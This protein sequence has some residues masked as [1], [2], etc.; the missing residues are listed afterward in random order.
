MNLD[1]FKILNR[2][3]LR[4]QVTANMM[5]TMKMEMKITLTTMKSVT[6]DLF[7]MIVFM[8]PM[9]K[10]NTV[11]ITMNQVTVIQKMMTTMMTIMKIIVNLLCMTVTKKMKKI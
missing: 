4:T 5:T 1:Y 7:Q 10:V 8:I 2:Y 6:V 11:T 9:K 3:N